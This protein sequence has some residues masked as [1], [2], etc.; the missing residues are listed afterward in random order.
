MAE[1]VID[2]DV[3]DDAIQ[4]AVLIDEI[5]HLKCGRIHVTVTPKRKAP[6]KARQV[7]HGYYRAVV[8][9]VVRRFL[10]D[11]Q[12]GMPDGDGFREFTDAEAHDWIKR[13]L[14]TDGIIGVPVVNKRTGE[15]TGYVTPSCAD[16]GI[17]EMF[18]FTE[19]VAARMTREG[20]RVPPPDKNWREARSAAEA[21]ETNRRGRAA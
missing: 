1:P 4:R 18:R 12:G 20:C 14:A 17:M 15:Q 7:Q 5:V 8:L 10:N 2:R 11:T 13:E 16:M 9:P 3:D 6:A 21:E 19:A